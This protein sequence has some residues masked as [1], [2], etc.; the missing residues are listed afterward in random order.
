MELKKFIKENNLSF[1]EGQRNT[2]AV[3]LCGYALHINKTAK[4]YKESVKEYSSEE[5]DEDIDRDYFY[6]SSNGYGKWWQNENAK[7]MYKF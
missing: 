5:L 7:K 1:E 4:D 2:N 3:I 6:V